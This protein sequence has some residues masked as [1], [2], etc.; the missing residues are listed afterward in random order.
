M[1]AG[2]DRAVTRVAAVVTVAMPM[3]A[4]ELFSRYMNAQVS[5]ASRHRHVDRLLTSTAVTMEGCFRC[6]G[7]SGLAVRGSTVLSWVMPCRPQTEAE[8]AEAA[9]ADAVSGWSEADY[10]PVVTGSPAAIHSG[11]PSSSRRTLKPL[12]LRSETVSNDRTQYGPR[13]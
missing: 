3:P 7:S 9:G 8:A 4:R 6:C 5:K 1:S 13:Q 11:I 12:L 2:H 10:L